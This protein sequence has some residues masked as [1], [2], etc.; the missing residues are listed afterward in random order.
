MKMRIVEYVNRFNGDLRSF[1]IEERRWWGWHLITTAESRAQAERFV[2]ELRERGFQGR[3]LI[4]HV[5]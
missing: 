5:K 1:D 3:S 4:E 2:A